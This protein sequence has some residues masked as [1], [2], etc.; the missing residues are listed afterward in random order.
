[1]GT[2]WLWAGVL[3]V[4]LFVVWFLLMTSPLMDGQTIYRY[5]LLL[6]FTNAPIG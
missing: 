3:W 2:D 6:N 5:S 1:M 4:L